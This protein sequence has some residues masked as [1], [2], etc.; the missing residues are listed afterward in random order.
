MF[1]FFVCIVNLP[2]GQNQEGE[3]ED[4]V[5]L[6]KNFHFGTT[7]GS[8]SQIVVYCIFWYSYTTA[9]CTDCIGR[10]KIFSED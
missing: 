1:I 7:I 4:P 3:L 9:L 2:I 6:F 10:E 8:S 5:V